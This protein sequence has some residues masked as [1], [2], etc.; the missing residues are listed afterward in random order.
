MM[1]VR[2]LVCKVVALVV[3]SFV[4]ALV[5]TAPASGHGEGTQD[6][7]LRMGTVSFWDVSY[8]LADGT[9]V[10][11]DADAEVRQGEVVTIRGT[12]KI[13]ESFP[14]D[15]GTGEP[16]EGYL[17]ISAP[18]PVVVVKEKRLNGVVAPHA[19]PIANGNVFNFE[20]K[21]VARSVGRFHVHPT[22]GVRT[23]GTLAGPGRY[24]DIQRGDFTN[25][26]AL[27]DGPILNLEKVGVGGLWF[28][29]IASFVLGLWWLLSWIVP[30]PTMA[31][32][33]VSR[34]IPLNTD[35]QA[36]GLITKK[37]HRQMNV[38]AAIAL[39]ITVGGLIYSAQVYPNSIA[40]QVLRQ[41]VPPLERVPT[42]A[43]AQATKA[44]FDVPSRRMDL[45][46][47][48]ENT[49]DLPLTVTEFTTS[50][51]TWTVA[52]GT[53]GAS[54]PGD[55]GPGQTSEITLQ[56]TDEVWETEGLIPLGEPRIQVAGTARL[57]N[58]TE[59]TFVTV[60]SLVKPSQPSY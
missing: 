27:S 3:S 16:E 10:E 6:S 35:G 36:Y 41:R 39:V 55:I 14:D 37:D 5:P 8:A 45:T 12:L 22:F 50:M 53:L 34:Q 49:G 33:P 17:G 4:V 18:G 13:L 2:E 1:I 19:I 20:I 25:T 56:I 40:H 51:F 23:A 57:S 42:F 7:S 38:I 15:L 28:W 26:V 47:R 52:D 43:N 60:Q 21:V 44:T 32:F 30:R 59:D 46:L 31:R 24:L 11:P 29:T 54:P 58:G 48:I 9:V